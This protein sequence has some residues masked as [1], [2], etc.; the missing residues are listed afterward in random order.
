[1]FLDEIGGLPP[2]IQVKLLRVA[3]SSARILRVGA[4]QARAANRRPVHRRPPIAICRS[5]SP[6]GR[7][8]RGS[9]LFRIAGVTLQIPPLTRS[10]PDEIL[11]PRRAVSPERAAARGA[12]R[13][14][15]RRSR[16]AARELLRGYRWPGNVRELRNVI[17]ARDGVAV[18]RHDRRRP[19]AG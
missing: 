18:R 19:A 3:S 1:V 15:P 14:R 11:P 13:A 16:P 7:F 9:L 4:P 8:P 2:A 12:V 5:R 10:A 17:E 6:R